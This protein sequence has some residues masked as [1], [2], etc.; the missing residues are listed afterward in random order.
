MSCEILNVSVINYI[1]KYEKSTDES[2]L[3][4]KLSY[5]TQLN[6]EVELFTLCSDEA[7]GERDVTGCFY[8]YESM[9]QS[10]VYSTV[11]T[12]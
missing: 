6:S 7:K 5:Y 10:S 8:A 1:T 12:K 3:I 4:G 2:S 9:I 11:I